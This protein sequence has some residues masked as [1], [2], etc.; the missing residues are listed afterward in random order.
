MSMKD[1]ICV[2]FILHKVF[3]VLLL[4]ESIAPPRSTSHPVLTPIAS[5]IAGQ[6]KFEPGTQSQLV[7]I[8]SGDDI[9]PTLHT[10]FILK[11]ENTSASFTMVYLM[12]VVAFEEDIYMD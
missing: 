8:G 2:Q 1:N 12:Y 5:S 4:K 10:S 11:V 7:P 9:Q 3:G 6:D